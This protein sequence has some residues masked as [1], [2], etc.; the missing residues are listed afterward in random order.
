MGNEQKQTIDE[1]MT[2]FCSAIRYSFNRVIEG[3]EILD[4]EI[5]Q[6]EIIIKKTFLEL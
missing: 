6:M 5:W 2:V 3:K 1:L 4:I